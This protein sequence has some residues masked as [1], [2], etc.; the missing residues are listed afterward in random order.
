[1]TD[2]MKKMSKVQTLTLQLHAKR[3]RRDETDAERKL[4]MHLRSRQMNGYKFRR[5][6]PIGRYIVDFFCP[7]RRIVVEL[8]GGQHAQQAQADQ[9]RSEFLTK[10]GCRVLRF[11]DKQN[12]ANVVNLPS[13]PPSPSRGEGVSERIPPPRPSPSR[14]EGVAKRTPRSH[15]L[16]QEAR[17]SKK[18]PT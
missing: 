14:G 17:E 11:S 13:P 6:Q 15:P 10:A 8:D 4:W 16:P 12:I 2:I 18:T 1:V 7:E 5:Q 3:L 9:R